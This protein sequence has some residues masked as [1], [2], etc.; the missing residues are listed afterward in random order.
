MLTQRLI[1]P[2]L[3]LATLLGCLDPRGPLIDLEL[4]QCNSPEVRERY[5]RGDPSVQRSSLRGVWS[6]QIYRCVFKRAEEGAEREEWR[7]IYSDPFIIDLNDS[8]ALKTLPT[9]ADQEPPALRELRIAGGS[10]IQAIEL[11]MQDLEGDFKTYE[12]RFEGGRALFTSSTERARYQSDFEELT[13]TVFSVGQGQ[14]GV[15]TLTQHPR[16]E[17]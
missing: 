3:C 13:G 15:F 14:V 8:Q 1:C 12:L 2:L 4:L 5:L 6:L 16:D 7:A 10:L 17:R 9:S 11:M